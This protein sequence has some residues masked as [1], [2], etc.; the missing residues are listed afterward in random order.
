[1]AT[2][3]FGVTY[4]NGTVYRMILQPFDLMLQGDKHVLSIKATLAS[5]TEPVQV[6]VTV[7]VND[8]QYTTPI[9]LL[10]P[11]G[12]Y[13]L[14]TELEISLNSS[15]YQF[16]M[17]GGPQLFGMNNSLTLSLM[18]DIDVTAFFSPK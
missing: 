9:L 15:T 14:R 6:N 2:V 3:V 16:D 5:A 1:V 4:Y 13:V 8:T 17:W 18:G 11:P 7:W 12:T 10:L